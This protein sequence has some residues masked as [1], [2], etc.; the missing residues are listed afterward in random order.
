MVPVSRP[1]LL[2]STRVMGERARR[3]PRTPLVAP[4]NESRPNER[5]VKIPV[6]R[7]ARWRGSVPSPSAN[8][9]GFTPRSRRPKEPSTSIRKK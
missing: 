1:S 8:G 4:K 2:G 7:A 3:F 9:A 5:A 6:S